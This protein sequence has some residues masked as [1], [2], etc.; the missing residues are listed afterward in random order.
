MLILRNVVILALIII[1]LCIVPVYAAPFSQ[2]P[3]IRVGI[4][5]NQSQ[6]VISANQEFSLVE[7]T[8]GKVLGRYLPCDKVTITINGGKLALNSKVITATEVRVAVPKV[9]G[10]D[11]QVN[12]NVYRGEIRLHRTVGKQGVTA[13]NILPLEKYL[14]GIVPKEISPQWPAETLK[15]QAVAARTYAIYSL[16]KHNADG[17]DV[18]ADT[19][20]QVY[21]GLSAEDD[22]TTAA[23]NATVGLVMV[24]QDKVIPA[25]FHCSSGGYTENSENVWGGYS[26]FLRGVKDFDEKSPYYKWEKRLTGLEVAKIL[27]QAGYEIGEFKA[28]ELS[29]LTTPGKFAADRGV[30]GR[31]KQVCF[32]GTNGNVVLSG[33]EVRRILGLR[34]SLFDIKVQPVVTTEKNVSSLNKG[35]RIVDVIINGY[36]WGHG[37]GLS[38]W[39]AKAMAEQA[40][41]GNKEYF[42]TI[43][44]HYYSGVSLEKEY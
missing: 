4:L 7:D 3:L 16:N 12:A 39:G 41:P 36:G 8:T 33:T 18:C 32:V 2:E 10:P 35:V 26:Q 14:C 31:V 5:S 24:Y 21:G 29:P 22:R 11:I 9:G 28:V 42:K 15:A 6:I 44:K 25:V 20:C 1:G 37:L 27:G 17:Y 34:S 23:V 30:S 38:Q 40:M 19:D 43:L 13:V